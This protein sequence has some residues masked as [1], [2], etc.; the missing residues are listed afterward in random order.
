MTKIEIRFATVL[1]FSYFIIIIKKLLVLNA[2][3]RYSLPITEE[4]QDFF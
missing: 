1:S 4:F 2:V 3:A